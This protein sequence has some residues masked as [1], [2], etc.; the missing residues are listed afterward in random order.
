MF[1]F[2]CVWLSAKLIYAA[3]A[4]S[5]G[6]KQKLFSL[7]RER[8][9]GAPA[10]VGDAGPSAVAGGAAGRGR[11]ELGGPRGPWDAER[12]RGPRT[13]TACRGAPA[14][15]AGDVLAG[16]G[17]GPEVRPGGASARPQSGQAAGAGRAA[18]QYV[19]LGLG[20]PPA[21]FVRLRSCRPGP[22]AFLQAAWVLS[23]VLGL[24]RSENSRCASSH[25]VSCS[26]CLALGPDCGWCVHEDFISGGPRSERCDIV[27]N[28]I[29]KGCP[30]DSIEYP[31]V[32]VTIPSENE[33]NTQVT[34]GE[35][36]IQL[37]P[38]AAAN[39]ML[40]IHP[41]KKYPVDLYYLVDV[42]ASMHNNIEKLNSVGND[43]SRKMAF[44]SRDFRLGFGSY[45]DKTV[46][47]YI[48]IHPER[49][50]NQCSDYNLDCM[51][52]TDTSMCC[53]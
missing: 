34:P 7:S 6:E 2:D 40:K 48:S 8:A 13:C 11:A 47:P 31:S 42:S 17:P 3:Q 33:V 35:V 16:L 21:A 36:S 44:F 1:G 51:P 19:R 38:G 27:S 32:H 22:A 37:R 4:P 12:R 18:V 29:S 41:L 15:P 24:G 50:H 10:R 45:V 46:S 14:R 25:A 28:L 23:L 20:L 5:A 9:C 43:L 49:I 30:V 39:F 53:P 26:E 52:P